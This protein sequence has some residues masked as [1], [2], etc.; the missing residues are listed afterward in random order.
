VEGR[1]AGAVLQVEIATFGLDQGVGDGHI[2]LANS[3]MKGETAPGVDG[4]QGFAVFLQDELQ[5]KRENKS[6]RKI[7]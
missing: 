1:A 3:Q 4:I 2:L 7:F 5:K 6:E